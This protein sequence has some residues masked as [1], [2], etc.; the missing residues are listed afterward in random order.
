MC[1][2]PCASH[3]EMLYVPQHEPWPT[4]GIAR[5]VP[6]T[7]QSGTVGMKGAAAAA[8]AAAAA[9]SARR[10]DTTA[11]VRRRRAP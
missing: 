4:T 7:L 9:A 2:P 1:V 10:G 11:G 8:T 5:H 6:S 3:E